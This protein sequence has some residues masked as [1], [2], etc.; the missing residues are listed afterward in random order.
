[1]ESLPPEAAL[2][3]GPREPL[4]DDHSLRV[5]AYIADGWKVVRP[6]GGAGTLWQRRP[7]RGFRVARPA[8][9]SVAG[10]CDALAG[11]PLGCLGHGAPPVG[12]L[13][14]TWVGTEA[15]EPSP[16]EEAPPGSKRPGHGA[17]EP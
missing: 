17:R 2:E 7:A 1:M 10:S 3:A 9:Q 13:F 14:V 5:G 12:P 16:V 11:S 15:D 4:G 6:C 8:A